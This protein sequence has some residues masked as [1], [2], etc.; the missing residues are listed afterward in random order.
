MHQIDLK[1]VNIKN[2][3]HQFLLHILSELNLWKSIYIIAQGGTIWN[4]DLTCLSCQL[5]VLGGGK[6][7][8][9]IEEIIVLGWGIAMGCS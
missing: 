7:F 5:R 9:G 3:S 2:I 6:A 1:F 8:E 4:K